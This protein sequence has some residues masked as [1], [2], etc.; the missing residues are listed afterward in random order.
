[1]LFNIFIRYINSGIECVLSK[2]ADDIKLC[3]AI[4]MTE[5]C[6]AVQRDLD[7]LEQWAQVNIMRFNKSMCK[8][9]HL[10]HSNPTIS[11]SWGM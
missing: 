11:T 9:L 7:R 2:P 8:V 3:D 10:G 4:D 1:M 6:H 5:A